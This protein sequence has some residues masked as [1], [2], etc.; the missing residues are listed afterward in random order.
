MKA[1][2]DAEPGQELRAG[3]LAIFP[4]S[5]VRSGAL[6]IVAPDFAKD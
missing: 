6:A 5:G 3:R 4:E 2:M 1:A